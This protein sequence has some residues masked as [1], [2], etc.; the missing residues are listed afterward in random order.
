VSENRFRVFSL[1]EKL[2]Q[3]ATLQKSQS[4]NMSATLLRTP[5]PI[6]SVSSSSN[7]A[8]KLS[9]LPM[10]QLTASESD[11]KL[12]LPQLQLNH[13]SLKHKNLIR[14]NK[15]TFFSEKYPTQENKL[16][17]GQQLPSLNLSFNPVPSCRDGLDAIWWA[18]SREWLP[19]PTRPTS[20]S[21]E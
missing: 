7:Y 16:P 9:G 8:C 14:T 21:A 15:A 2:L 10:I 18:M 6:L 19:V 4:T 12:D 11:N 13:P 20:F 5:V 1:R 3:A 17:T